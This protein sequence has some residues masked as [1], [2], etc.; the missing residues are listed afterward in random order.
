MYCNHFAFPE[1][2]KLQLSGEARISPPECSGSDLT[3]HPE[4]LIQTAK[5]R[6]TR[7]AGDDG[8]RTLFVIRGD[9][10]SH[11]KYDCQVLVFTYY[12]LF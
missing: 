2:R 6:N 1:I 4:W 5:T 10:F 11:I 12:T 3:A 7:R 9:L 8:D